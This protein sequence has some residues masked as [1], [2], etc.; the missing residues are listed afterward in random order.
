[1]DLHQELHALATAIRR[2]HEEVVAELRALREEREK[3]RAMRVWERL[4]VVLAL[5]VGLIGW[6]RP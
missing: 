2:N 6:W 5:L 3:E 1:M 4:F